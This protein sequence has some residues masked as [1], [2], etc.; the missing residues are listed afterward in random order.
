MMQPTL[1]RPGILLVWLLAIGFALA[2]AGPVGAVQQPSAGV[3]AMRQKLSTRLADTT[4]LRLLNTLCYVL[5]NEQPA[6]ALP[7]GEAAV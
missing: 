1:P 5:H 3:E 2:L 6:R 7:Y 4:R